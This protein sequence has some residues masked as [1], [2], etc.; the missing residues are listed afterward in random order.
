MCPWALLRWA[1]KLFF[2]K[3]TNSQWSHSNCLRRMGVSWTLLWCCSSSCQLTA[4]KSHLSQL[5]RKT[6]SPLDDGAYAVGSVLAVELTNFM[7]FGHVR[8]E[9]G[10]A[11]N[12]VLGPNGTGKSS[13]VCALCLGLAN[14][15]KVLGRAD[16]VRCRS[17][18]LKRKACGK[19]HTR[20]PRPLV[21]HA[22][23]QRPA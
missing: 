15:P 19:M 5:K 13:L 14:S 21:R 3:Q 16:K 9:P 10:P 22:R 20:R 2:L 6:P 4:A 1:S 18:K 23:P 17:G 11:L 7:T 12:L 8:F